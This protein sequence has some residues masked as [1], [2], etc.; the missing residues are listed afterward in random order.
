MIFEEKKFW[1]KKIFWLDFQGKILLHNG[2]VLDKSRQKLKIIGPGS[3]KYCPEVVRSLENR[4]FDPKCH[5]ETISRP[6]DQ[7]ST[8]K[9]KRCAPHIL[10][11]FGSRLFI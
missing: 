4:F 3:L 8:H 5:L 1:P 9:R 11:R 2:K 7:N 6:C 10:E